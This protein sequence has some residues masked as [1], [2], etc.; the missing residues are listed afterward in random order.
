MHN[1]FELSQEHRFMRINLPEG[2]MRHDAP[3]SVAQDMAELLGGKLDTAAVPDG[4]CLRYLWAARNEERNATTTYEPGAP[5]VYVELQNLSEEPLQRTRFAALT[6]YMQMRGFFLP[7]IEINYEIP[8][9]EEPGKL[10]LANGK[11]PDTGRP[12]TLPDLLYLTTFDLFTGDEGER[13][14]ANLVGATDF[15]AFFTSWLSGETE[16]TPLA[17][18]QTFMSQRDQFYQP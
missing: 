13:T 4:K 16:T 5:F 11:A 8:G 2:D 6:L 18:A 7:H 14:V 15:S 10:K 17:A 1:S 12:H 3:S 9:C